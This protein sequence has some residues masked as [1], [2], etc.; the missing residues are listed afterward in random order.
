MLHS[1]RNEYELVNQSLAFSGL[2]DAETV[3]L[4]CGSDLLVNRMSLSVASSNSNYPIFFVFLQSFDVSKFDLLLL[5]AVMQQ[6]KPEHING[7]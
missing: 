5:G 6:L 4:P 7:N 1:I 2:R 3:L